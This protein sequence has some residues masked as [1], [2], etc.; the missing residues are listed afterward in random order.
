MNTEELESKLEARTESQTLDFKAD[1]P[2]DVN[3]Y[4]KHIL[5]MSNLKDG[6]SIIIGVEN[7]TFERQGVSVDNQ[8]TYKIDEMKDQMT[9]FAD[10]HVDF[11]VDSVRDNVGKEYI[12]IKVFPFKEIPVI[13]RKDS[14]RADLKAGIVYYRNS[15][16]RV[17]SAPVSNSTDMRDIIEVATVK[18]MRRKTELGFT[19]SPEDKIKLDEELNGL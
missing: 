10:P 9:Q 12:I 11:S 13:C 8:K 18:M 5:A 19:V 2:W 14:I 3:Q 7:G 17:E 1:C 4:A 6:G 15:N 16:R